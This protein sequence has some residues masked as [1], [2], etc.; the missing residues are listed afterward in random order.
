MEQENIS[1]KMPPVFKDQFK[2]EEVEELLNWFKPRM[3]RLPQKLELDG[4]T[5]TNQLPYTV[6]QLTHVLEHHKDNMSVTF[7]GYM[8]HLLAIRVRLQEMGI[9]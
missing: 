8:A 4:A 9:D 1:K 2:K 5:S 6:R 3:E 7:N